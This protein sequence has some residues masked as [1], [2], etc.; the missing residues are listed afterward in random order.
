MVEYHDRVWAIRFG[1]MLMPKIANGIE[2]DWNVGRARAE[3]VEIEWHP[4]IRQRATTV[5]LLS[6]VN[7]ANMGDYREAV[8]RVESG[9]DPVPII[10]NTRQQGRIKYG[11]GVNADQQVTPSL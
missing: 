9:V 6:Y 4:V 2:L 5:R 10:E 3:N 1:G 11:F 8:Q 7:H